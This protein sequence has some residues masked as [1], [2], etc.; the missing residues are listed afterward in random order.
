MNSNF[1]MP[2]R[3]VIGDDC[4]FS[5]HVLLKD[6]GKKALIVSGKN[7]AKANGSLADMVRT[8]EANGQSYFLYD[9]VMSNP[10]VDCV[11]EAAE[12]TNREGCD[13]VVGLGGGSPM[14]AA[15]GAAVLALNPVEKSALFSTVFT[16]ALP[17]VAVPTTAGTG[18]EVTPTA[19]FTNHAAKTKT[20]IKTPAIFPRYAFLDAKYTLALSRAITI[21]TAVDALTHAVEGMLSQTAGALTDTLAKESIA[22]IAGCFALLSE[23]RELDKG[24]RQKLLYAA[25]LAGMVIANT[26]TNVVHSMG[27]SLTYHRNIDHG[28]ANGLIFAEFLKRIEQ[29]EKNSDSKRIPVILSCLNVKSLEEFAGILDSLFGKK[30]SFT[31]AELEQYAEQASNAKSIANGIFRFEKEELLD[32]FKKSLS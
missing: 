26:G 10:T 25:M 11:Y 3:V 9:T 29:K 14:D 27:Y 13:F 21:N 6:L 32:I 30:E 7:S 22:V 5:N 20:S 17:I 1:F 24:I 28:R 23:D 4:I 12:I 15:K 16:T 2:T 19:V 31:A 8:L 18:S